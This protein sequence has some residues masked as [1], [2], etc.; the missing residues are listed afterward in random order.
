MFVLRRRDFE[1][2]GQHKK[3]AASV[4]KQAASF[5]I[6]RIYYIPRRLDA[7]QAVLKAVV[8]I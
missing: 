1:V 4:R 2:T 6:G 3:I 8:P 7:Q 5:R